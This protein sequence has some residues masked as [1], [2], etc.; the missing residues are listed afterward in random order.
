MKAKLPFFMV[1]LFTLNLTCLSFAQIQS[2]EGPQK[3]KLKPALGFEYFS[4]TINWDEN[5]YNSTLKSY[6][7]M[8]N[9]EFV[10]QEGFSLGLL[11]GYSSSNCDGMIFRQLP[12]SV[13]LEVG[14]ISGY[15]FGAEINKNVISYGDFELDLFAQFVYSLGVKNTWDIPGLNVESTAEG[16][17]SWMRAVAG[18]LVSYQGWDYFYPYLSVNFNYL[19][20]TFEMEETVQTLKGTED[21]KFTGDGLFGFSL[22]A[23]YKAT[24]SFSLK[25]EASFIPYKNGIDLGFMLKAAYSF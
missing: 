3:I 9:L 6:L 19:W 23:I 15:L 14:G 11:L 18:P 20:G 4:R 21:K 22:G 24:D 1:L 13:E 25:G 10:I 12:F 17:P 16:K 2:Q 5:K 8:A 7:F